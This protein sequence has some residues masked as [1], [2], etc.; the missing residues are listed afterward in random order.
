VN[1]IKDVPN[2][3]YDAPERQNMVSVQSFNDLFI[4][5][6]EDIYMKPISKSLLINL[7][8]GVGGEGER[9]GEL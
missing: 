5:R 6:I 7:K 1:H 9:G 4:D 2:C 3:G 8:W